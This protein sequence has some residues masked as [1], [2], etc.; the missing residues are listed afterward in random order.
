[1]CLV[2]VWHFQDLMSRVV[3]G[4]VVQ[5]LSIRIRIFISCIQYKLMKIYRSK[6]LVKL[7]ASLLRPAQVT[8]LLINTDMQ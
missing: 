4:A 5:D 8:T 1:M 7:N 3:T 6:G 2:I